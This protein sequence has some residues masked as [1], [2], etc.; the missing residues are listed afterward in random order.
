MFRR[1]NEPQATQSEFRNRLLS[2]GRAFRRVFSFFTKMRSFVSRWYAV[3]RRVLFVGWNVFLL[4]PDTTRNILRCIHDDIH[5]STQFHVLNTVISASCVTVSRIQSIDAA[6]IRC[7][8]EE[9][10]VRFIFQVVAR[11]INFQ[12]H[13]T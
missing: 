1:D 3:Q 8:P 7:K 13:D 2:R 10:S 4:I 6:I 11:K 9:I 12:Y 5:P